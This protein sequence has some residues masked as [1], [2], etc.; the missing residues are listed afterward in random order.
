MGG[1]K[2]AEANAAASRETEQG[3]GQGGMIGRAL[4]SGPERPRARHREAQRG[5]CGWEE[6]GQ[7]R[8]DGGVRRE[9]ACRRSGPRVAALASPSPARPGAHRTGRSRRSLQCRAPS[10]RCG[11]PARPLRRCPPQPPCRSGPSLAPKPPSGRPRG[12]SS[13]RPTRLARRR[14]KAS[15]RRES[16]RRPRRGHPL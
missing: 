14:A 16:R 11:A 5:R 2:A 15:S 13:A 6:D 10:W 9:G 4:V 8:G 7:W 1:R 3:G 12:A